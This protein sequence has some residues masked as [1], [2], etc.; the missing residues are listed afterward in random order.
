[1]RPDLEGLEITKG[2]LKRLTGIDLI[3]DLNYQ[4]CTSFLENTAICHISQQDFDH[5]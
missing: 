1:M 5:E 4:N 2:K 3:F